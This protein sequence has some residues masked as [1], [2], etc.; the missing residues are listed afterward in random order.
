M[1]YVAAAAPIWPL[2]WNFHMLQCGPKKEKKKKNAN[3]K[4]ISQNRHIMEW[5]LTWQNYMESPVFLEV[6]PLVQEILYFES[7]NIWQKW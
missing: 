3:F 4:K 5:K 6:I 2:A 1:V 7:F